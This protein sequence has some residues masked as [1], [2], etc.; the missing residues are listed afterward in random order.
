VHAV[1]QQPQAILRLPQPIGLILELRVDGD[2]AAVG[3]LQLRLQIAVR[4]L[5]RGVSIAQRFG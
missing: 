3:F 2:D 4:L 5:Q 1:E